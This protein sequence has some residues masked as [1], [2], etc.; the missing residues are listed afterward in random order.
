MLD[1]LDIIL[2]II[3][4]IICIFDIVLMIYLFFYRFPQEQKKNKNKFQKFGIYRR[5]NKCRS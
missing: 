5:K 4:I 3:D 1:K 2:S